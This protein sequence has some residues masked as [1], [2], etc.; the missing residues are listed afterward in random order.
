M[1]ER[2]RKKSKDILAEK[3]N[4]SK[5]AQGNIKRP[6]KKIKLRKQLI[7]RLE[8][9]FCEGK[10]VA[11]HEEKQRMEDKKGIRNSPYIHDDITLKTYKQGA[12]EFADWCH[13]KGIEEYEDARNHVG[14]YLSYLSANNG[15]PYTINTRAAALAKIF[16]CAVQDFLCSDGSAV[17][18]PKRNRKEITRSRL[19]TERDRH[20]SPVHTA[21][22][23]RFCRA[24][25][26]RR[27]EIDS[28]ANDS[29]AMRGYYIDEVTGEKRS[30]AY[31]KDGLWY[32]HIKGKGGKTRE[33]EIVGDDATIK[34]VVDRIRNAGEGLVWP[35]VHS[36]LDIHSLRAEYAASVYRK[37]A[38]PMSELSRE[39]R[40]CCRKE[41]KGKVLDRKAMLTASRMLGHNRISVF[42]DHYAWTL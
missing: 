31:L 38:R 16:G 19:S 33:A 36:M 27:H 18:R 24:T 34:E 1:S 5:H 39:D 9:L 26:I 35:K 2:R 20:V 30:T 21:A 7:N 32:V 12:D 17:E 22:L 28:E 37:Y 6:E 13:E 4:H 8:V 29:K 42:A 15:N 25:G 14:D 3:K 41:F 40:Y 10:G 23:Q 11:R